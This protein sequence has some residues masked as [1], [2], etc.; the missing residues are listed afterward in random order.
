MGRIYED[1]SGEPK[2]W[3]LEVA[4]SPGPSRRIYFLRSTSAT[5]STGPMIHGGHGRV[6]VFTTKTETAE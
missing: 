5:I 3:A 4:G 6:R 1:Q 2:P